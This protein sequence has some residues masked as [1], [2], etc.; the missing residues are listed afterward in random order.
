MVFSKVIVPI[1]ALA[2]AD[3]NSDLSASI[4]ILAMMAVIFGVAIVATAYGLEIVRGRG[5]GA[6]L[7]QQEAEIARLRARLES[8]DGEQS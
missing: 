7:R 6:Q 1:V 5:T 3:V 2:G 4:A 8:Q